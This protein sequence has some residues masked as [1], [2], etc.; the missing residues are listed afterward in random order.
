MVDNTVMPVL[1][2]V[3]DGVWVFTILIVVVRDENERWVG[4]VKSTRG[5][6]ESLSRT[7]GRN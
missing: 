1:I 7:C 6:N 4:K 2:E 3:K 5:R